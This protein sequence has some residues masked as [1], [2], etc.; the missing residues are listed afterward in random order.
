MEGFRVWRDGVE[1]TIKDGLLI[2][3][4]GLS[5]M[6]FLPRAL[7][8]PLLVLGDSMGEML[9]S[10]L[11][12]EG[13]VVLLMDSPPPDTEVALWMTSEGVSP[14]DL[15]GADLKS[16]QARALAADAHSGINIRTPPANEPRATYQTEQDLMETLTSIRFSPEVCAS[17]GK[18]C[19]IVPRTVFGRMDCGNCRFGQVCTANNL[20]C[21][22]K[23]CASQ[24]LKCGPSTD[25]CGGALD[26]GQCVK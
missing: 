7:T 5:P 17:V 6:T 22:P 1:V 11:G 18:E 2:R 15:K 4:D 8:P 24:G 13:Q 12:N 23:T 25:G 14:M 19:G 21:K 16:E 26:C 20:C 3:V 9:L 10:P